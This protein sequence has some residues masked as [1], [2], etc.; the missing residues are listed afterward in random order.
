MKSILGFGLEEEQVPDCPV[1]EGT[2]EDM[3]VRSVVQVRFPGEKRSYSYYN[4]RFDLHVNDPVF[5][6]G[7]MAGTRGVVVSVNRRFKI[8]LT[9]YERVVARPEIRLTGTYRPVLDMM[10]SFGADALSAG[11]FR[12]WSRAPASG[13][14]GEGPEYVTGEGYSFELEDF[15]EDEDVEPQVF[16]R[17]MDYCDR[18][19]VRYLSVRDGVGTAFVEGTRCYEI[20]FRYADGRVS[21]L[22]CECPYDGLCKHCLAVLIVLRELLKKTEKSEFT[23]IGKDCFFQLIT[24]NGQPVT[25]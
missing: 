8:D 5:V 19:R 9:E 7:K 22:Y 6:S 10:V 4:D 12:D 3:P 20:N 17:A 2:A 23:A 15:F 25:L 11:A 16:R 1:T 24:F 13:A 18:G 14:D 21:D